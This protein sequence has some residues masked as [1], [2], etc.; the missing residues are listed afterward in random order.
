MILLLN[1]YRGSGK[2]EAAAYL[3]DK[4]GFERKA[5]ADPLKEITA[6]AYDIPLSWMHDRILKESALAKYPVMAADAFSHYLNSFMKGEYRTLDGDQVSD[7][8]WSSDGKLLDIYTQKPLYHTVRSLCILKG[9]VN[10]SVDPNYW[11]SRT[12]SHLF[13]DKNYV[14]PDL[15]YK[16]E[17]KAVK[18]V[19]PG[20]I[21]TVRI[22]RFGGTTSTDA[23]ERDMDNFEFDC[24]IDNLGTLEEYIN[25]VDNFMKKLRAINGQ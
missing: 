8:Y 14:I 17:V 20:K 3:V 12:V 5:F 10:R 16:S 15:R 1:G 23:S 25:N 21:M 24:T 4:Y 22:N 2:D 9:S 6:E 7:T 18:D 13:E 19:Y 11:V